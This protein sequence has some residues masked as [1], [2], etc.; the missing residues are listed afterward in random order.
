MADAVAFGRKVI[1]DG[2]DARV[3]TQPM[4]VLLFYDNYIHTCLQTA[5]I[6]MVSRPIS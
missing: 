2:L 3:R 6:I 4:D 1:A 5:F